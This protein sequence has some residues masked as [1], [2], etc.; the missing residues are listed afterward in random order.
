M[1]E[2]LKFGYELDSDGDYVK[3]LNLD[4][5]TEIDIIVSSYGIFSD[6]E[7]YD[8]RLKRYGDI[9]TINFNCSLEWVL[10]LEKLL[11]EQ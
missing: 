2:L 4:K 10:A 11:K 8:C 1:K 5:D 6:T 7:R 9:I 3:T